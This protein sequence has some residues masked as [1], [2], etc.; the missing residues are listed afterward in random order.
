METYNTDRTS[1]VRMTTVRTNCCFRVGI[2]SGKSVRIRREG[3]RYLL[4]KVEVLK[5]WGRE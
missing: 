3:E 1:A 2:T 4:E 5:S